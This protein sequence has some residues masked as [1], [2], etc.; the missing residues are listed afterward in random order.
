MDERQRAASAQ[1]G[2]E[3]DAQP[4]EYH[5]DD[6]ICSIQKTMRRRRSRTLVI[7]LQPSGESVHD[8]VRG[9][10]RKSGDA[11]QESD[12]DVILDREDLG[13]EP[14]KVVRVGRDLADCERDEETRV[15]SSVG[16]EEEAKEGSR[17]GSEGKTR[18]HQCG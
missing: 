13:G 3:R 2:W 15:S 4:R 12:L 14:G 5:H 17:R 1:R 11:L 7:L 6:L 8:A 9:R 16:R 10:E 18:T